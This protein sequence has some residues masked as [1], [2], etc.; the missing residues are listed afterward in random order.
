[1]SCFHLVALT[2][3]QSAFPLGGRE[4]CDGVIPC[5]IC[6]G[7]HCARSTSS[8]PCSSSCAHSRTTC[9][10][11]VGQAAAMIGVEYLVSQECQ[12]QLT[13]AMVAHPSESC[14]SLNPHPP[15]SCDWGWIYTQNPHI[16]Y[17]HLPKATVITGILKDD[18]I[19]QESRKRSGLRCLLSGWDITK[20][21]LKEKYV[22]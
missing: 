21:T 17:E 15:R 3:P 12:D 14:R 11:S 18:P 19:G 7:A 20:C 5:R 8:V 1:M 4:C 16:K 2:L 13:G 22:Q 10:M 9:I 6:S